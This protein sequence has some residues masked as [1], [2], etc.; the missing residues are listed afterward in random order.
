MKG[1]ENEILIALGGKAASEIVLGEV[2]MGCNKDMNNAYDLMRTLL[3][4]VTAYD[5]G[6]WC[7]GN[8]TSRNVF[9]HLDSATSVELSRYYLSAKKILINNRGFLDA[10]V[11]DICEKKTIS[12]KSIATI[13]KRF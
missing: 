13:K 3:D 1:R 2:D 8:E 6:S 10:I 11:E 7:H 12:Y 9:D 4:D 5:F